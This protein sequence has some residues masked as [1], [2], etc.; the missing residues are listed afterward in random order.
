MEAVCLKSQGLQ[1]QDICKIVRITEATFVSYLKQFQGG[2]TEKLKLINFYKPQGELEF[3]RTTI[4][5]NF[6]K[7]LPPTVAEAQARIEQLTGIKR[8]PTQVK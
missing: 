3:Y 7:Q 6:R 4:E 2:D 1:H 5:E 8:S